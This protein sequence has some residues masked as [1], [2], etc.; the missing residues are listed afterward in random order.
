MRLNKRWYRVNFLEPCLDRPT[1]A[2]GSGSFASSA[3]KLKSNY[4]ASNDSR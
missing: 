4:V 1:K 3:T 2:E